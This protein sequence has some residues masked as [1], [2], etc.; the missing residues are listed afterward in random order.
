VSSTLITG[1]RAMLATALGSCLNCHP[2]GTIVGAGLALPRPRLPT[3]GYGGLRASRPCRFRHATRLCFPTEAYR[4]SAAKRYGQAGTDDRMCL[5]AA[6]AGVC[7][8]PSRGW[9]LKTEL[10]AF[11]SGPDWMTHASK[12][13]A[14]ASSHQSGRGLVCLEAERV[15]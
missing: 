15:S 1:F 5:R 12:A 6:S 7:H 3:S 11:P 13:R 10:R 8:R 9:M 2:G 4:R 14:C